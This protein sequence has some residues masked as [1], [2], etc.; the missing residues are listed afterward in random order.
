MARRRAGLSQATVA[1]AFGYSSGQFVSNW[2]RGVSLPPLECLPQLVTLLGL[3]ADAVAALY[4]K[5]DRQHRKEEFSRVFSQ[6][7]RCA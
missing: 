6:G 3:S 1:E 5:Y 2:E 4:Y 7:V